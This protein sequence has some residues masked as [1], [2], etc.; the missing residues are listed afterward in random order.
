MREEAKQAHASGGM[1]LRWFH[2]M[3]HLILQTDDDDDE[4]VAHDDEEQLAVDD[5]EEE[6]MVCGRIFMPTGPPELLS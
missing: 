5:E 4:P 2:P 3:S 1:L 6:Q